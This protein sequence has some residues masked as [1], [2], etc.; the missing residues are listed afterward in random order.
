MD[1]AKHLVLVVFLFSKTKNSALLSLLSLRTH[2]ELS[3]LDYSSTIQWQRDSEPRRL[4]QAVHHVRCPTSEIGQ[5]AYHVLRVGRTEEIRGALYNLAQSIIFNAA[6]NVDD[7]RHCLAG[8]NE[9]VVELLRLDRVN[10]VADLCE[11]R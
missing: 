5:D 4:T 3:P 9:E 7:A 8:G 10:Q 2:L 6:S 1:T 11:Q